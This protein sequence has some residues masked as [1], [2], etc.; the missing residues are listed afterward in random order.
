MAKNKFTFIVVLAL[1]ILVMGLVTAVGCDGVDGNGD[2]PNGD[3]PNG[4]A[5]NGD[6]PNGDEP[7]GDLP[8]GDLPNGDEPAE[9]D[10]SGLGLVIDC[11]ENTGAEPEPGDTALD[12][13]FQDAVGT[14]FAL[15]DFRGRV[16]LLDFWATWCP[17]CNKQLPFLQQTH[18]EWQGTEG[19]LLITIDKG[20]EPAVMAAYMQ[21]EG[22]SF[23]VVV[24]RE[25]KV[26]REYD[27]TGIPRTF[28]I[29]EEGIIQVIQ[30]GY[31]HT[32][33]DI[34]AILDPLLAD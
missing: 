26:S 9:P 25:E 3:I 13:R 2:I 20:E 22:F 32:Y 10:L 15:S 30:R 5:P 29:D 1:V 31:F 24:D 18:D 27:V 34:L 19:F 7:N 28:F 8:N 12:F 6:A 4:D 16:V 33:E 14:T 21:D 11:D 17:Y 23:P